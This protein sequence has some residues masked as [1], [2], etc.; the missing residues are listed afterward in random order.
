MEPVKG[1][2]TTTQGSSNTGEMIGS[3]S[4]CP[5]YPSAANLILPSEVAPNTYFISLPVT[6]AGGRSS[7][8]FVSGTAV[9]SIECLPC[10]Q[11][12]L[13]PRCHSMNDQR[14]L[15]IVYELLHPVYFLDANSDASVMAQ[16]C[17]YLTANKGFCD[18]TKVM[19]T[20]MSLKKLR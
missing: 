7:S 19:E 20:I 14:P 11:A 16:E 13:I 1:I 8:T 12:R 5:H 6:T 9:T 3:S 15:P 10:A 17:K 18:L 2:S 4:R